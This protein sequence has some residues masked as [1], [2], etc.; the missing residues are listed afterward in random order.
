MDVAV[1]GV[2]GV[3]VII[4]AVYGLSSDRGAVR[5]KQVGWGVGLQVVLA[6]LLLKVP[7]VK[8]VFGAISSGVQ[9][10]V[11][12]GDQGARYLFGNLVDQ[13]LPVEVGEQTGIAQL[14]GVIILK[15]LPTV[16]FVSSAM[17]VF[18]H[19]GVLQRVVAVMSWVVKRVLRVSGAEAL[20]CCANVF[21]GMTEAPLLVRPYLAG[22]TRSEF[23]VVMVGG[24]ATIA[25]S[26]MA[27]YSSV[28]GVSF[29]FLLAASVLNAP[30]AIYL[31][32][33]YRP[34]TE[35]PSTLGGVHVQ[36]ERE[37]VNV[38][39][40]A[41]RGATTGL[42]LALNIGALL[43]AFS[44]GIQLI[45][46]MLEYVGSKTLP[47]GVELSLGSIFGWIF[48]PLAFLMGVPASESVDVGQL[49]GIKTALNEYFAYDRLVQLELSENA[50]NIATFALCGFA[51]L[52]SIAIMLGGIGTLVPERRAE[53]AR[54]GM[55][56]MVLGAL[57]NCTTAAIAGVVLAP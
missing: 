36:V 47:E 15:I 44:A 41:A 8:D 48:C 9:W 45:D 14:G 53:L 31:A 21:L 23:L 25:G 39:D 34:E 29:E 20:A 10:F 50:R 2:V 5:W 11:S 26:M 52:G 13:T 40:A 54:L 27:V 16:I 1:S 55:R 19:L 33:I 7:G 49:L 38:I 28:F 37:T 17:T 57:A 46:A 51:N 35:E 30:A 43:L 22:M 24:F 32:K 12:F 18:Y 3:M 56:A 42:T 6:L 4:A